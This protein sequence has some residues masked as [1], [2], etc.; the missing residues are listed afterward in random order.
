MEL[1]DPSFGHAS[2]YGLRYAMCANQNKATIG[3]RRKRS[4]LYF[5][6]GISVSSH[7]FGLFHIKLG[8]LL[9][10]LPLS[11]SVNLFAR[12]HKAAVVLLLELCADVV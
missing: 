8:E 4:I 3:K 6:K 10:L 12:S 9:G 5:W 1:E 11:Q 2:F 7:L